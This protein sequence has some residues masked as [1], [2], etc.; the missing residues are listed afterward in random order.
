MM[1]KREKVNRTQDINIRLTPTERASLDTLAFLRCV[2]LSVVIR[3]TLHNELVKAG[4]DAPIKESPY[5]Q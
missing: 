5:G 4:L 2:K 1:R 3:E